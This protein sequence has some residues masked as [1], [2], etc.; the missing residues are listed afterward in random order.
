MIYSSESRCVVLVN[1]AAEAVVIVVVD[2]QCL[3]PR[4]ILRAFMQ[5]A[6]EQ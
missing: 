5:A 6:A 1:K 3:N 2:T 4:Q